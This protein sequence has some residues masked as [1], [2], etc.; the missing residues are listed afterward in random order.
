MAEA[1][2]LGG[3]ARA[4]VALSPGSFSQASIAGID[5][6]QVPWFFVVS[7]NERFLREI[8]AAVREQSQSVEL[9]VVPGERH[10]S[11]IL[12]DRI[13]LAER[14]A[15]WLEHQLAASAAMSESGRAPQ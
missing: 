2:R 1:G 7:R 8:T 12:I 10:A 9:L 11:D 5:E 13:D 3:Y 6:S 15:V 14:I 4:Y